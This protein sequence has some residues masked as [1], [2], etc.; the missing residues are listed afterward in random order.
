KRKVSNEYPAVIF[1]F[2]CA[3]GDSTIVGDAGSAARQHGRRRRARPGERGDAV[4]PRPAGG[5]RLTGGWRPAAGVLIQ[6]LLHRPQGRNR[7]AVTAARATP[8]EGAH[9]GGGNPH[10]R[11][12][13]RW[14]QPVRAPH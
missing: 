2:L 1:T 7:A 5:W 10:P 13:S 11:D 9:A 14:R 6:R 12:V 3:L 4:A 8:R